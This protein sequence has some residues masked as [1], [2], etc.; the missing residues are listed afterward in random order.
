MPA[1]HK[2]VVPHKMPVPGRKRPVQ[3][4]VRNDKPSAIWIGQSKMDCIA[5]HSF[6]AG[7]A[8]TG[9]EIGDKY[10]L[11]RGWLPFA[12]PLPGSNCHKPDR[13]DPAL[14]GHRIPARG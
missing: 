9:G 6:R 1:P 4:R 7:D 12:R 2:M 13:L 8:T 10:G 3:R 11:S 5:N 14:P